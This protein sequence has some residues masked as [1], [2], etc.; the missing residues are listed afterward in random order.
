VKFEKQ[1]ECS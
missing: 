1:L